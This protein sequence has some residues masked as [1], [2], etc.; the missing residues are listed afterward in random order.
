MPGKDGLA[1]LPELKAIH[2]EVPILVFSGLLEEE[3]AIRSLKAGASGFISKGDIA[4]QLSNAIETVMSGHR[5]ISPVVAEQMAASVLDSLGA[6][7]HQS[8]SEREFQVMRLLAG[9]KAVKEIAADLC[10]SAK[11]VSTYRS[12]V[13]AKLSVQS[14]AEIA[15]Y[16]LKNGLVD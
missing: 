7:P 5:Y 14:D 15:R 4:S 8:L 13:C 9:G 1:L 12:R 6:S 10:L 16:A 3:F 2:S 11:T